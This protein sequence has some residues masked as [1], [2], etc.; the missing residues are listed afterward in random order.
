M[1]CFH[2]AAIYASL[3]NICVFTMHLHLPE[4]LTRFDFTFGTYCVCHH[5]EVTGHKQAEAVKE[6]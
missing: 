3:I 4:D 2:R 1:H 6:V 5:K